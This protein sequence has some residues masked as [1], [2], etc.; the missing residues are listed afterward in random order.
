M[1][2]ME[3]DA[4]ALLAKYLLVYKPETGK[5]VD[6]DPAKDTLLQLDL[7]AAN[8]QLTDAI[9]DDTR[10]FSHWVD[11]QLAAHGCRFAI[12]GYMEH[13]TVYARSKHFNTDGEP[14]R[15]HL[16]I[17]IW[18]PAQT[19]VYAP[20][21]G[22]VHSFNNNDNF[23]DYGPTIILMHQVADL[24][25]YSLYGHL[26]HESQNGL[27]EG[28]PINLNEQ[29]GVFGNM[30]ENGHWPPHLHFQLML[31]MEGCNGDYPGVARFSEKQKW[32]QNIPDP[33]LILG[34]PI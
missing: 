7:T 31:D 30:D 13:R 25:F 21:A 28:K 22:V 24:T 20:L 17:D 8:T 26:S 4:T 18:G 27:Y 12:G 34:L 16:G 3:D 19:P 29:I 9:I 15:L 14:R 33:Q 10:V 5:V 23:G 11:A 2:A 6:F 1:P 32:L